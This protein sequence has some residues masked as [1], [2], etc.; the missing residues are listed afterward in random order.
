MPGMLGKL[1]TPLLSSPNKRRIA[2]TFFVI[3]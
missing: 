3:E 1:P 2:S